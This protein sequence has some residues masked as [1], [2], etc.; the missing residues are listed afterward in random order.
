M[1]HWLQARYIHSK[2]NFL[3]KT[4]FSS[5]TVILDFNDFFSTEKIFKILNNLAE[6]VMPK[7]YHKEVKE[8]LHYIAYDKNSSFSISTFRNVTMLLVKFWHNMHLSHNADI[9][10]TVF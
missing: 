1:L 2:T 6:C 4:N 8:H 5:V 3:K 9:Y 7:E 10:H